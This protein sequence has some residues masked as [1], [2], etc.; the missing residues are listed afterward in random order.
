MRTAFGSGAWLRAALSEASA[1]GHQNF[2]QTG[3]E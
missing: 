3:P 2:E 1:I